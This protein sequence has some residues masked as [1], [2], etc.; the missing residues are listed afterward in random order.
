MPT[1]VIFGELIGGFC[2]AAKAAGAVLAKKIDSPFLQKMLHVHTAWPFNKRH[3]LPGHFVWYRCLLD[4]KSL[5][6]EDRIYFVFFE[7]FRM[8]YS[9][10]YLKHLKRKYKNSRSI[11]CF[12]N[13]VSSNNLE[14]WETMKSFYDAGV[15]LCY[16]DAQKYGLLFCDYWP[17]LLPEKDFEPENASD[18]FF[19]AQAKGR[20]PQILSV[21]EHLQIERGVKCDFTVIGVPEDQRRYSGA[22]NYDRSLSYDEVLQRVRNTKCVLEILP[23]GKSYSSLRV[24][25]ALWYHK[26][27]L[28]TNIEAPREWFYDPRIVQC[29]S[30]AKNIDT[31]FVM[32]PLSTED[33]HEIFD[34]MIV[35]DFNRFADWV[36]QNTG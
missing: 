33:E 8:A 26:K 20:L 3:N 14:K 36:I 9:R 34:D 1:F 29:F 2:P 35:G 13:P 17:C 16:G 6:L 18:V 31:E 10:S 19:V 12:R 23:Y 7:G 25:E 4:E 30:E 32:R 11:F 24:C 5:P 28:T 22:I 21:Y 27:L 15:T